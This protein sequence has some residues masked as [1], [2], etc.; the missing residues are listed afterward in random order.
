M[1]S[2]VSQVYYLEYP[3]KTRP[4]LKDWSVVYR[5]SPL[6]YI[7]AIDTENP[8]QVS[9][10]DVLFYQEDGLEGT[11]VIDLGDGLENLTSLGSDEITDPKELEILEKQ[12]PEDQEDGQGDEE[13]EE[14]DEGEGCEA[15]T[16][17]DNDF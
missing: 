3:C 15:P 2:Q 14:L 5:V 9:T 12:L 13:D 8:S 6:G 17:D 10:H 1:A 16:Y 7:P 11:F 4:D